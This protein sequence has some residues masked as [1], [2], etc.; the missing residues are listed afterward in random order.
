MT[1]AAPSI[2]ST[3]PAST[4]PVMAPPVTGRSESKDG[5]GVAEAVDGGG[6]PGVGGT[7]DVAS[8]TGDVAG[9]G[10][11]VGVAGGAVGVAGGAVGVAVGP[12]W[13][14]H[15]RLREPQQHHDRDDGPSQQAKIN[16]RSIG[17]EK[18]RLRQ[19]RG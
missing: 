14:G 3:P 10:G 6:V 16:N 1:I 2:M 5:C 15:P 13:P 19:A 12:G 9:P 11:T 7:W 8:G 17:S 18:Q 4:T